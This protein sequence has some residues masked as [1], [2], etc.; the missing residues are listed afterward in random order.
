[1]HDE[2]VATHCAGDDRGLLSC[3]G[4]N[5][6]LSNVADP[7]L[8]ACHNDQR[9]NCRRTVVLWCA[10]FVDAPWHRTLQLLRALPPPHART[11]ADKSFVRSHIE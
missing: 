5:N 9:C 8:L 3:Q 11:H 6:F 7:T 1:M 2:Y 4:E 10:V